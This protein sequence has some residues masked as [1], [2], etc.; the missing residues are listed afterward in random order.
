MSSGTT[1]WRPVDSHP[2]G[3]SGSRPPPVPPSSFRRRRSPCWRRASRRRR[4]AQAARR[5][6]DARAF[7]TSRTTMAVGHSGRAT[8]A[9]HRAPALASTSARS[10]P[11]GRPCSTRRRRLCRCAAGCRRRSRGTRPVTGLDRPCLLAGRVVEV[12]LDR[13][14]RTAETHS[15][16]GDRQAL[17]AAE[18]TRQ[19]HSAPPLEHAV[20]CGRRSI[21]DHASRYCER[22]RRPRLRRRRFRTDPDPDSGCR[23]REHPSGNN[24]GPACA[25]AP[26][27]R[28]SAVR[29]T[30]TVS[31]SRT[32]LGVLRGFRRGKLPDYPDSHLTPTPIPAAMMAPRTI[33]FHV[34]GSL[35]NAIDRNAAQSGSSARI[36]AVRLADRVC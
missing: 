15:D 4:V 8:R 3:L 17:R 24:G 18:V 13:R 25:A 29:D 7:A 33:R 21:G 22:R 32:A 31:S 16:L 14:G 2:P 20:V 11:G 28:R 26:V 12:S 9:S 10:R 35:R 6:G 1:L 19:R 34:T 5:H 36:T 27:P 30:A 23:G